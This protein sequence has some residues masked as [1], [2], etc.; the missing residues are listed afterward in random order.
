MT[1]ME[2]LELLRREPFVP[3]RVHLK[4]GTKY[5]I[6]QP[7]ASLVRAHAFFV[8]VGNWKGFPDRT[9]LGIELYHLPVK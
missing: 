2:C 9:A 6:K 1:P 7:N 5:T 3:I 8:G 4:N